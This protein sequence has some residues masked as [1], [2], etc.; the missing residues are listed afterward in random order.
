M[1]VNLN[2]AFFCYVG[3]ILLSFAAIALLALD[4]WMF[5]SVLAQFIPFGLFVLPHSSFVDY[6]QVNTREKRLSFEYR[7]K[8]CMAL[9]VV[10]MIIML[11]PFIMMI[12][13]PYEWAMCNLPWWWHYEGGILVTCLVLFYELMLFMCFLD[14][15]QR[16]YQG[17][18]DKTIEQYEEEEKAKQMKQRKAVE[19]RVKEECLLDNLGHVD[20]IIRAPH[21]VAVNGTTRKILLDDAIYDYDD[22]L[23]FTLKDLSRKYRTPQYSVT[24]TDTSSVV[25]RALVGGMLAGKMGAMIGGVTAPQH[26]EYYGNE[27]YTESAYEIVIVLNSVSHPIKRLR[28]FTKL[29]QAERV[30]AL[31]QVIQHQKQMK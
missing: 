2:K 22:I 3:G 27:E 9:V 31:L 19:K 23:S 26:T 24:S 8:W 30:I 18:I 17:G 13:L 1:Y 25:G 7:S 28:G 20:K 12:P 6:E 10:E 11:Y 21:L 4:W 14:H 29:E 5:F 15:Y 16:V